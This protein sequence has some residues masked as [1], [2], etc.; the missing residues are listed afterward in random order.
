[1]IEDSLMVAVSEALPL[2]SDREKTNCALV[3]KEHHLRLR[4]YKSKKALSCP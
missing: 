2:T 1:M 4:K 3:S